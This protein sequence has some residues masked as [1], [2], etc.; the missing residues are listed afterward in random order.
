[1]VHDVR[2]FVG[3][4]ISDHAMVQWLR[5]NMKTS[6]EKR[7]TLVFALRLVVMRP[8]VELAGLLRVL[9]HDSF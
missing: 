8:V 7:M 9:A 2:V 1:M 3:G 6:E 5:R 4:R